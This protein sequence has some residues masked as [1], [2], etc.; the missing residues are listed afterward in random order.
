[1]LLKNFENTAF[2]KVCYRFCFVSKTT[3]LKNFADLL[4][5]KWLQLSSTDTMYTNSTYF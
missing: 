5:Q 4:Y 3:V 1:M 2:L